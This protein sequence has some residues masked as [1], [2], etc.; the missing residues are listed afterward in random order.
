MLQVNASAV[1]RYESDETATIV[2]RHNRDNIDVFRVGER[3]PADERSAVGQRAAHRGLGADRRLGRARRAGS[4]TRSSRTGYRSTAAAPIVVAGT[5]WGAVA[6]ASEDPLAPESREPAGSVLRARLTGRRQR[7]GARRPHRLARP[8][9]QGRRRAAPQARAQPSRR[10]PA[11]LRLGE[12]QAPARAGTARRRTRAQPRTC[13]TRSRASSTP[14]WRSC[15]SSRA[16]CT[17]RSSAIAACAPRSRR[18][19]RASRSR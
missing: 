12:H 2:G 1:L 4:P 18:S 6:I 14:V 19:R 11:A 9:G 13:S 7:A 5:L 8:P 15:A 16:G 17:P 10:R 3:L